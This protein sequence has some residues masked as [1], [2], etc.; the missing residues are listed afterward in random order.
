MS[1]TNVIWE[2]NDGENGHQNTNIF[3]FYRGGSREND[4]NKIWN[5]VS[6]NGAISILKNINVNMK[7]ILSTK[8]VQNNLEK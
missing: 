3:N 4:R 6:K 2:G 1:L 5:Q 8:M 7:K